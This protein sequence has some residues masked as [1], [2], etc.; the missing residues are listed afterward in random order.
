VVV[1]APWVL[2]VAGTALAVRALLRRRS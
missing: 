1:G 2:T